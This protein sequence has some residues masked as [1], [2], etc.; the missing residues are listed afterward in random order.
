MV[1]A[2][3]QKISI[4]LETGKE[5]KVRDKD[6]KFLHPGPV[7]SL[8]FSEMAA[9]DIEEAWELIQ[10]EAV[11]LEEL[12]EF[13]YDEFT[14]A[15]AWYSWKILKDDLYFSG[16][17][18]N[19]QARS[20]EFVQKE[21][22]IREEKRKKQQDWD[23]FIDR[24]QKK[25]L[26]ESDHKLLSE[27]EQFALEKNTT[28]RILNALDIKQS[29]SSAHRFLLDV[30]YWEPNHNPWPQRFEV[31]T[32]DNDLKI[33]ALAEEKRVDLTHLDAY[34]ID[35]EGNKDPD[36]AISIDG[37]YLWVHIADVA[38]LVKP[39]SHLDLSARERGANLYLPEKVTGM[40]PDALTDQLGLGLQEISPALSFRFCLTDEGLSD[41]SIVT[42][43]VKVTRITYQDADDQILETPFKEI[44][45]I[46][47]RYRE[48]RLANNAA[49]INLPEAS[50]RVSD[51]NVIITPM[52]KLDSR[53]LVSEAML[54]TGQA[55]ARF[56]TDN[57][58]SISYA[59]QPEPEE[60]R[61]PVKMSEMCAYRR[62]FRPSKPS[63]TPDNHFGLGVPM[64]TRVT[65]PM[66][67]YLDLVTHQQIRAFLNDTKQLTAEEVGECIAMS[68]SP[69]RLIR[70]T[71]RFS[72]THWTR[73]FLLQN[74]DWQGTATIIALEERKA[75][76]SI[77]DIALETKIRLKDD[78]Q[79]DEEITVKAT[80]VDLAEGTAYFSVS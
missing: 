31:S 59:V 25:S 68:D 38:A 58:I 32:V 8:T 50:I 4:Q 62:L 27:V 24:L 6:V 67:R 72:N 19:I 35:D 16:N 34:A 70:K 23:D 73:V 18:K 5:K 22:A 20:Q 21:Q 56:A 33:P 10:G 47:Q 13:L 77:H 39:G 69:T 74:P 53:Q 42:S 79:L 76:I 64:Y 75:V 44:F 71:E 17:A 65:S 66:R 11:T 54:M 78:M 30:G 2:V 12:S 26:I 60:I 63:L 9:P 55:A 36:D 29:T 28:S 45:E 15:T 57:Q 3:D 14:P 48:Q 46:T 41:I 51:G 80:A 7:T 52:L 37:D 40:L 43:L 49:Q 61:T 1:T